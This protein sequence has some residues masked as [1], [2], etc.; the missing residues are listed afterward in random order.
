MGEKESDGKPGNANCRFLLN[1][2]NIVVI[3]RQA[4][5]LETMCVYNIM[6]LHIVGIY[7]F[8]CDTYNSALE[9]PHITLHLSRVLGDLVPVPVQLSDWA[10]RVMAPSI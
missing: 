9:Y 5:H 2:G 4:S 10:I 7:L 3:F 1:M 8:G 6:I